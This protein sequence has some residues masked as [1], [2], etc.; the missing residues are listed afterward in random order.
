MKHKEVIP[1]LLDILQ[2]TK[3][4]EPD[5]AQIEHNVF[6]IAEHL[7]IDLIKEATRK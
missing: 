1:H 5:I 7:D 3:S 6:E 4:S 2:E